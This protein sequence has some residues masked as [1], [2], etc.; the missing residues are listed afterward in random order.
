MLNPSVTP[1]ILASLRE[2]NKS[3]PAKSFNCRIINLDKSN[4]SHDNARFYENCKVIKIASE[5]VS[6]PYPFQLSDQ[7]P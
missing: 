4:R 5:I 7:H 6:S 3:D 2:M 1:E